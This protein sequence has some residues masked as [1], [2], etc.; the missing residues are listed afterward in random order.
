MR[1]DAPNPLW[2]PLDLSDVVASFMITETD[3]IYR[4]TKKRPEATEED[5]QMMLFDELEENCIT[6][7]GDN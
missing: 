4:Q 3:E 2:D 6:E 1:E 5:D 7:A